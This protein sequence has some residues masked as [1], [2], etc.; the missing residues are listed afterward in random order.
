MAMLISKFHRLIQSKIIWGSFAVLVCVAFA[1]AYSPA[2]RS[3]NA[4]ARANKAAQLA[5][6]L[7]GEDV[8]RAEFAHAYQSVRYEYLLRFGA[9][10]I[11][12]EVH[13]LLTQAAWER[14]AMLKEAARRGFEVTP[15]QIR[16]TIS[17]QPVFA[18]PQTHQFDR[19]SYDAVIRQ[20]GRIMRWSPRNMQDYYA[21]MVLI[22]KVSAIPAQSGLVTESEVEERFHLLTDQ[23]VA[24][25]AVVPKKLVDE[26]SVD[27]KDARNYYE[28]NRE[29]FRMPERAIVRYV[30]FPVS[31]YLAGVDAPSEDLIERYYEQNKKEFLDTEAANTNAVAQYRSLDEVRDE[32]ANKLETL[33]ARRKAL[34]Q[35]DLMVADLAAPKTSF[36]QAAKRAGVAIGNP[37][38]PFSETGPPLKGIDPSA[39]F[40]RAALRLE[41]DP[42]LYYSDPVAGNEVV[43]VLALVKKQPSFVPGFDIVR[44]DAMK[45]ARKEAEAEAYRKKANEIREA[46]A[47]DLRKGAS[48]EQAAKGQ[49]LFLQKTEPFSAR[50]EL[51]NPTAKALQAALVYSPK[52]KLAPLVSLDDDRTAIAYV[53]EKTPGNPGALSKMRGRLSALLAGERVQFLISVWGRSLLDKAD[54]EDLLD[55]DPS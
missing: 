25:Y 47:D 37:T 27:E 22:K 49:G 15:E 21:E 35:A 20:V 34:E 17:A 11:T 8:S 31:N 38:H 29:S 9:F 41:N 19:N 52:G 53:A 39:P 45:A 13:E 46:I 51:E 40:R 55:R 14:M 18:N 1:I 30:E 36:E 6:R 50:T 48:F 7:F 28:Q 3:R 32:I 12:D 24:E 4:A 16:D 33:F 10:E 5:G 26:I 42:S 54:F 43:Y 23:I 2:A 44:E